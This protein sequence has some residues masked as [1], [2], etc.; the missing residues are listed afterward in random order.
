[1]G[2]RDPITTLSADTLLAELWREFMAPP[3]MLTVTQWAELHRILSGK[4]SA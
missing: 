4:D 2:A 1:M 3:P